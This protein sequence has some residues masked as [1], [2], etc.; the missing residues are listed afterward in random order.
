MCYHAFAG[1]YII[2]VPYKIIN[3]G[4]ETF[5]KPS[6]YLQSSIA[7]RFTYTLMLSPKIIVLTNKWVWNSPF[8]GWIIRYADFLPV[9]D[10][11]ENNIEKLE[12]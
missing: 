1:T 3:Q 7:C 9:I 4:K 12:N 2:Q 6:H 11:I 8:Y 10:G 5:D